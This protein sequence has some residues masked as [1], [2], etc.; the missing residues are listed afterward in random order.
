MRS[1]I[2]EKELWGKYG[3]DCEKLWA[4]HKRVTNIPPTEKYDR[5]KQSLRDQLE[6]DLKALIHL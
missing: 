6:K 3:Q 1:S 5:M 2:E 4:D